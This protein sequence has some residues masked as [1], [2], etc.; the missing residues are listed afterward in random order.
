MATRPLFGAATLH[1]LAHQSSGAVLQ[2][3]AR[4]RA[5]SKIDTLTLVFEQLLFLR[6]SYRFANAD[7]AVVNAQMKATV[8]VRANPGLEYDRRAF[9]AVIGQRHE[10]TGGAFLAYW[11]DFFHGACLPHKE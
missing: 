4:S 2:P 11:V 3:Q 8:R 1:R 10:N 5:R 9:S 7:L 6:M